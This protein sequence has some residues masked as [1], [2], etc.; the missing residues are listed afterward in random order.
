MPRT[1]KPVMPSKRSPKRTLSMSSS[2]S[3]QSGV[4]WCS[5]LDSFETLN[6]DANHNG[7]DHGADV[8]PDAFM[9]FSCATPTSFLDSP[10]DRADCSADLELSSLLSQGDVPE[11]DFCQSCSTSYVE[12]MDADTASDDTADVNA[13]NTVTSVGS[14]TRLKGESPA[15]S[16]VAA[17]TRFDAVTNA[18]YLALVSCGHT[19]HAQIEKGIQG[20]SP[21]LITAELKS[22]SCS[23]SRCYDAV[24]LA[25]RS[26]DEITA[27]LSTVGLLSKRVQKEDGGYSLRSSIAFIPTGAEDRV[28]WELFH[29]GCCPRRS[30]CQWY[31]PQE[32]DIGRIKVSIRCAEEVIGVK[33]AEQF[34]A[35]A[36][37]VR[38]KISLGELVR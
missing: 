31:H 10:R 37:A 29:K 1:W 22:G 13:S 14:W 20:S 12:T 8:A 35:C 17:D 30:K 16:P 23:S 2:S 21:T 33:G 18:V 38:H 24:H 32:S 19:Q 9:E 15:Y 34:P 3:T 4:S 5:T 11:M 27:R 36:Q 28:C 26:L 6:E 25:R 7:S